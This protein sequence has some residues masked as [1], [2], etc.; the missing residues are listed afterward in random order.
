[1]HKV[2]FA[3]LT[4]Y[5]STMFWHVCTIIQEFSTTWIIPLVVLNLI[6]VQR[7]RNTLDT[8]KR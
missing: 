4:Y 3:K 5:V 7:G 1:V 8:H 6:L 2:G